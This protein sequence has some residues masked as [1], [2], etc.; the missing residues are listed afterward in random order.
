MTNVTNSGVKADLSGS[1]ALKVLATLANVRDEKA[2]AVSFYFD[3][4][5]FSDTSHHE[6]AV[7]IKHLVSKAKS[8]FDSDLD[9]DLWN[10]LERIL[11]MEDEIRES[12]AQFR[13]VF[14]CGN[15]HV[16]QE[17][18]LPIRERI[19]RLA[20]SRQFQLVPLLRALESSASH[21]VAIVE[22]DK[23]RAFIVRGFEIDEMK[24]TLHSVNLPVEADDSRVGWSH[25]VEGKVNERNK[26]YLKKLAVELHQLMRDARCQY[27]VVGCREDLWAELQPE[28]AEAGL[29]AMIA[30][31]FLISSF[32]QTPHGVLQEAKP[33]LAEKRRQLYAS[34]WESIEEKPTQSAVGVD[35]V[36]RSL[37]LGRVHRLVL[38]NLSGAEVN[39]C[40]DCNQWWRNTSDICA[41]CGSATISVIPAEE[42][43]LRKALLTGA[44]ILTTDT[45]TACLFGDVGAILRY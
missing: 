6:E 18:D 8:E 38:G 36:L 12:P 1:P 30:G 25:H 27:L 2:H 5:S 16:W 20:V 35:Q 29:A 41:A 31:H 33:V 15:K 32:D 43:L 26:A 21:C 13:A 14:A 37:E 42:L 3:L 39:E 10:N 24:D 44:E 23:A 17:F 45:A 11:K 4:S 34:V 40:A 22:H 9:D 7:T 19:S 28:L